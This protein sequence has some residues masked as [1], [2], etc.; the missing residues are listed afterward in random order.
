M[1]LSLS[2]HRPEICSTASSVTD[3]T[4]FRSSPDRHTDTQVEPSFTQHRIVLDRI[5][6]HIFIGDDHHLPLESAYN[7]ITEVDLFHLAH[8][9][10]DLD[11]IT[12]VQR[13]PNGDQDPGHKVSCNILKGRGQR[14]RPQPKW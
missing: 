3:L 2:G 4:F 1:V 11:D 9:V 10:L 14:A 8:V 7:G 12:H 6:E 5:L 13:T